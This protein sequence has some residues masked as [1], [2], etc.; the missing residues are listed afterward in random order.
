MSSFF[1]FASTKGPIGTSDI[2]RIGGEPLGL[3]AESWPRSRKGDAM[4]HIIT[5]SRE[6]IAVPL[7]THVAAIAVF[8]NTINNHEAFEPS[9]TESKVVFLTKD[10]LIRGTTTAVKT[11]GSPLQTANAPE[12][13]F[14]ATPG[15]YDF[16]K[17]ATLDE[18]RSEKELSPDQISSAM[19]D[20]FSAEMDT[21]IGSSPVTGFSAP[22][23]RWL[24]S[25][26]AP[27]GQR[28]LFWFF[29]SLV[30]GFNCGDG[31]MYVT[32]NDQCTEGCAWYQ[33]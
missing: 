18:P 29:D 32:A 7:P 21:E 4:N 9:T 31:A 10:D 3:T 28:V 19:G 23:V 25:A 2:S 12:T 14:L 22:H 8:T 27:D 1:R 30:P 6:H 33:C 17:V 20:F 15:N 13:A 11:L 5:V 26:E 16:T 24:Q